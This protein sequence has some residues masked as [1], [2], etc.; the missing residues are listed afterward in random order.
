MLSEID[1]SFPFNE[2]L[3][4]DRKTKPG[5]IYFTAGSIEANLVIKL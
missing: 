1:L 3:V 4:T 5:K 2:T